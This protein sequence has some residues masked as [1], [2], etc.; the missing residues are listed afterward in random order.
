MIIQF[1]I[2]NLKDVS[3]DVAL[4]FEQNKLKLFLVFTLSLERRYYPVLTGCFGRYP[5]KVNRKF[6]ESNGRKLN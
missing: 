4:N 5:K 1:I 6:S 3:T 2:C